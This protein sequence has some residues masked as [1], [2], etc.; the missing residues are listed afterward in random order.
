MGSQVGWKSDADNRFNTNFL[1]KNMRGMHLY[2][3]TLQM[4]RT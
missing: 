1:R 3:L 4:L 2:S